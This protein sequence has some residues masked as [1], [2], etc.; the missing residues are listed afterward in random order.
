MICPQCASEYREG[1]TVCADCQVALIPAL[2]SA[3][4]A[5]H[6]DPALAIA[7]SFGSETEG[8]LARG[9]LASA[10]I[11]AELVRDASDLGPAFGAESPTALG[12]SVNLL[13]PAER[14]AEAQEILAA[15]AGGEAE[16]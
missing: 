3:A 12:A 6:L 15:D 11:A 4:E 13:V 16:P 2:P 5:S 7:G 1:F 9:L 8:E 14:L 10:G